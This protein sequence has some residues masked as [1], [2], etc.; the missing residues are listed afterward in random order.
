MFKIWR[1]WLMRGKCY[2]GGPE[3][4]ACWNVGACG[5]K[6]SEMVFREFKDGS[7]PWPS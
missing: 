3:T 4:P 5:C 2:W 1:L 7:I 6:A